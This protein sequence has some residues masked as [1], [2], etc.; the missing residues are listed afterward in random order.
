[1]W[2]WPALLA[3]AVTSC[4]SELDATG[5]TASPEPAAQGA[6]RLAPGD[7]KQD[8]QVTF[9]PGFSPDGRT[10]FFTQAACQRV[11][12]CP[13]ILKRAER[14]PTGW[15][16]PVVVSLPQDGRAD[17]P[18]VSP[19]GTTLLFSWAPDRARHRGR[20]V[21]T[22]F[23]LF[24]LDLNDPSAQPVAIDEPDI[25]RI[26]GGKVRRL[27][28]VN[29][30]T[31]PVLTENGDLYF[32]SERLD[33]PGLRDV[34]RARPDG[35]GS[36]TRPQALP[37]PINGPGEDDGAWLTAD[38]RVML[39]N[40]RVVGETAREDLYLSVLREGAWSRPVPLGP[41]VNTSDAE[42][43]GRIT[44]DGK[45]FVFTSDRPVEGQPKGIYQVWTIPVAQ[46][47]LVA[48]ALQ[49]VREQG[50]D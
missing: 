39:L 44:P 20:N 46:V 35:N 4:G 19:D 1:M 23:D 12:Q 42:I 43:A 10:I 14:T 6:Q 36:F 33:G 34:Y 5:P 29:N 24:A 17:W 30:E 49:A 15:T 37:Q 31:A 11:W 38:G 2:K 21:E 16:K 50:S 18:S 8:G 41:E 13:Q 28:F 25:N 32:W 45:T 48:E 40:K 26:R 27:R 22:D 3:F 7:L 9:S 47:P